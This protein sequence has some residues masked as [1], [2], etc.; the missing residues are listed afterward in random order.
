[1]Q[2]LW[3]LGGDGYLFWDCS[4]LPLVNLRNNFVSSGPGAHYGMIGF[5]GSLPI[6]SAP[7]GL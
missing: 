6:A 7:N 4:F 3:W 5:L 1:M 2:V